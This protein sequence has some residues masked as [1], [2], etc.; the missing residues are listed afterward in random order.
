MSAPRV[1]T[2][3]GRSLH[4]VEKMMDPSADIAS[5]TDPLDGQEVEGRT[6]N[7]DHQHC[8]KNCAK[9]RRARGG[10]GQRLRA[11]ENGQA[12]AGEAGLRFWVKVEA[13]VLRFE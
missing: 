4:A 2:F 6:L 9:G 13:S 12:P 1:V 10:N 3:L 11:M 5:A 8:F 7:C